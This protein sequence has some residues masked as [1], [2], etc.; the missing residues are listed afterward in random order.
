MTEGLGRAASEQDASCAGLVRAFIDSGAPDASG[1]GASPAANSY[2][3]WGCFRYFDSRSRGR[4]PRA[5]FKAG[6][7]GDQI[8]LP[9]ILTISA[10]SAVLNTNEMMPCTVAVRRMTLSVMPTSETCAVMPIT[11]EK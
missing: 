3:A 1:V 6:T 4:G 2:F 11:N 5:R 7:A 9:A 10:I 8:A